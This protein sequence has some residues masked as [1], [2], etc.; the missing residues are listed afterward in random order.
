VLSFADALLVVSAR[1]RE[2]SK[3][4]MDD[5]GCMAAVFAPLPQ[6]EE[7]LAGIDGYVVLANINSPTQ[8]VIGGA[9]TAVDAAIAAFQAADLRAVKI[10]V[11]HAFHTRIVAPASEPLKMVISNMD[12]RPPQIPIIANVMG[13]RYPETPAEIIDILGQQV[14]S[15]VQF[16]KGIETLYRE[17]AR[18][19]VEVGPKRVLKALSEDILSDTDDTII[20]FTNHPRKGT[21]PSLN[22][23]LCG[24][25]AA[26]VGTPRQVIEAVPERLAEV[27]SAALPTHTKRATEPMMIAQSQSPTDE[28]ASPQ[29][30]AA[31]SRPSPAHAALPDDSYM[32]LGRLFADFLEQGQRIYQGMALAQPQTGQAVATDGKLPLTGSVV[33]SGAALGLPGQDGKVFN[34]ENVE[35]L[36]RGEQFIELIPYRHR[37]AMAEKRINRLVKNPSGAVFEVIDDPA[38]TIKLAGRRGYFDLAAEYGVPESRVEALDISTQ[39]AIAAGIEALRDAG[40]PLVMRYRTTSKGTFLPDRWM[41]PEGLSDETGVIFAS[42]FPGLDRMAEEVTRYHEHKSLSDQLHV[43]QQL[44]ARVA[45]GPDGLAADLDRRITRLE[46]EIV[47]LDYHF[48]RRF[49]FRVLAMGH[50]QFAEYIG[51]RG[52]NTHV[53]AA[54]AT[55]THAMAVAEDWIRSGRCRRVIVIA[56]DDVTSDNLMGWIGS[57]LLATGA[58]TT[59]ERLDR[60][61]LPFDRRRHGTIIGMGAAAIVVEAEDVVRERGMRG[62]CELLSSQIANSAYHGTRLDVDHI[63]GI[64]DRV[65][66]QAEER[67]G[68]RRDEIA[69]QTVFI[70]HETYTPARGGS[71]AAEIHALRHTFGDQAS[72]VVIANT[73]GYT[74]H[75]MGVGIEDILAVKALEHGI[76]PAVANIHNDFQPDQELGDL[77][78]S[79]GGSYPVQYALRLGAGFGSQIAMTLMRRIPGELDRVDDQQGYDRWLAAVA[80]YESARLEIEDRT[81]RIV[82]EGPPVH[83]PAP[84]TWVYG[85]GPT[86]WAVASVTGV[87]PQA[88][89]M[90]QPTA[91]PGPVVPPAPAPQ[92]VTTPPPAAAVPQQREAPATASAPEPS[93]AAPPVAAGTPTPAKRSVK[94]PASTEA[95][96]QIASEG[97]V[98]DEVL[99]LVSEKTGYPPD[100][101]DLDLD[102]EADLGIDTVKQAEVFA[103]I[104]ERYDIPRR[105]DLQLRDYNTLAKV[106]QFVH[107]NRTDQPQA[108]AQAHAPAAAPM[109]VERSVE[110]GASTEDLVIERMLDP[111]A[112]LEAANAL[113]R[114]VPVPILRPG[115]DLC[116]PTGV[117]Y[118]DD[119]RMIIVSDSGKAGHY[120]GYRLRARKTKALVLKEATPETVTAQLE[121]WLAEGPVDGVYFLT[122][123]D[124]EPPLSQMDVAGWRTEQDKRVKALYTLMRALPEETFLISATRLGGLH[125]YGA[126]GATGPLGGAVT[127]FTKAYARERPETLVK[128]LDFAIEADDR[129]IAEIL[130]E[131]TLRDPGAVE[132]GY[133]DGQRYTI[134]LEEC[135]V[136]GAGAE[137]ELNGETVFLITGAAG[138]ITSSIVAD[139][140]RASGGAFYL[141]DIAPAPDPENPDLGR[142]GGDELKYLKRDIAKRIKD[143]GTRPTPVMVD[144][145]IA[146]LERAASLLSAMREIERVGGTVHYR[147]C[148]VTDADA[149]HGLVREIAE[150][151]GRV[152]VLVHA[153]GLERSHYLA[154]KEPR[155]FNLIFDVK[156][157]GLFNL[158]KAT[159]ALDCPL[160]ASVVFTSIAGRFGNAGQTDYSAANDLM[161]KVTS[162]M[163]TTRPATKAIAIDWSAWGKIGMATRGSIP[164]MMRRAGIDML[165]PE[166]AVPVVRREV[167]ASG[168]G[169]EV[170][171]AG[172]LGIL[173]DPRD[174]DGGLDLE[175]ANAALQ[176][177][178]PVA[179]Q[180]TGVGVDGRYTFEA[181]LDP[182][183]QPFLH[184]HAMDETPLLPGVMGVEGFAEVASLIAKLG[185]ASSLSVVE[186]DDVQFHAPLKFYRSGA[187][188]LTWHARVVPDGKD[189]RAEVALESSRELKGGNVQQTRHFSGRVRLAP[190]AEG[191][192]PSTAEAPKWNGAETLSPEAIYR[193]YFHGPAFQVLGGV[194]SDGVRVV[195]RFSQDL[196]PMTDQ[197]RETL[198]APLLIELCLQTAGSPPTARSSMPRSNHGRTQRTS[199][200]LT[201]ACSTG[202][203]WSISR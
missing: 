72:R 54:C 58:T 24:L 146:A 34:D 185:G 118:S 178:Y 18:I 121:E 97:S 70:S 84:S 21:L 162:S 195:G 67:F 79:R 189:L 46:D 3:V 151:Q 103:T 85:H 197:E 159:D 102:L 141:T 60:A 57:G 184:D 20:L 5:N 198:V 66:G 199:W 143:S 145:E 98:A 157:D 176:H 104:R 173:L 13:E 12:V 138:G 113:L 74:G 8:V 92:A 62:I 166:A 122:A 77:N 116:K 38:D 40:I 154:D 1:G 149:V 93:L 71:A 52:P 50:S 168:T 190:Q 100:M 187:R 76:V 177:A 202:K 37:T 89:P 7:V 101:L 179:G 144:R 114:R 180:L 161:C 169:G 30:P 142:L 155:E 90:P 55:T 148:D 41:L 53:N 182:K 140:A 108:A 73:K 83:P 183:A 175:R 191:K 95:P 39:L 81:L 68:I 22:E 174:P 164:E 56:G 171:I 27:A 127:G 109:P 82:D 75:A 87:A 6:V 10:P 170:L 19:Y 80:G 117:E 200:P 203:A 123:L 96:A 65:V 105:E 136:A 132:I 160:R 69:A 181:E 91:T 192:G 135:P 153:A 119:G 194:Q 44:R 59:E 47:R 111:A 42:A 128:A 139:L 9:T 188:P 43:L 110:A 152:D 14:A 88:R 106:I 61:A 129:A 115:L 45:P 201:R 167:I 63:S 32:A 78:L 11:S 165:D 26:G 29:P 172:S 36:L 137:I 196:P 99:A 125:G 94:A 23:A 112:G 17:G 158:L 25:Y 163:R 134:V 120:L 133:Q 31:P 193:V 35:R 33:V 131:E 124:V 64:M 28:P 16:V 51:A 2:M 147:A 186:I 107:D 156:A 49:I 4:S 86:V 15:P 48:D 150:G 130:V 126:E